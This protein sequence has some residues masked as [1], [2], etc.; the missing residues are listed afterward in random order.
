[1]QYCPRAQ[2]RSC[3]HRTSPRAGEG[4][5][6]CAGFHRPFDALGGTLFFRARPRQSSCIQLS[7]LLCL[8][9]TNI[10]ES[11]VMSGTRQGWDDLVQQDSNHLLASLPVGH[12]WAR[13]AC[14]IIKIMAPVQILNHAMITMKRWLRTFSNLIG[15]HKSTY[16]SVRDVHAW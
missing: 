13:W 11:L 1:M 15:H 7:F 10:D 12:Q 6:Q 16:I 4:P 8:I 3:W 5:P 14:L 2:P 9:E